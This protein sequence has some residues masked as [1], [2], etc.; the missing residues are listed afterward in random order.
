MTELV[1]WTTEKDPTKRP[2]SHAALLQKL[3]CLLEDVPGSDVETWPS[4]EAA[5]MEQAASESKPPEE[6]V[7]HTLPA[8]ADTFVG[9]EGELEELAGRLQD[10]AR[11]VTVL[12][13]GGT[14]KTRLV[15]RYGWNRCRSPI[16][17]DPTR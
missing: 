14:G 9:R 13:P 10:G 5:R 15:R 7:R 4:H 12:G 2:P 3:D 17:T 6:R 1:R 8:E 11:L 16:P